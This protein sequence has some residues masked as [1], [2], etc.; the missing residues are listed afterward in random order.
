MVGGGWS[1][2]THAVA[3][4]AITS[5][6]RQLRNGFVVVT[7]PEKKESSVFRLRER[8][9]AACPEPITR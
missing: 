4:A 2:S 6:P 8:L 7:L 1:K 9:Y 3:D 5:R